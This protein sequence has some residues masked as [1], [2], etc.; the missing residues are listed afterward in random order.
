MGVM[1]AYA[2]YGGLLLIRF[3]SD[4]MG[5]ITSTLGVSI[6]PAAAYCRQLN[7]KAR[8]QSLIS[9]CIRAELCVINAGDALTFNGTSAP[10]LKTL[11]GTYVTGC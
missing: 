4:L 2:P 7:T 1:N 6:S 5:V 9:T 11:P 8:T 3:V 10:I